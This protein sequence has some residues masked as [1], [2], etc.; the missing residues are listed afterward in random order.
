[1]LAGMGLFLFG[2][3]VGGAIV[4]LAIALVLFGV[5]AVAALR[6]SADRAN[7][8]LCFGATFALVLLVHVLVVRF[9]P[10][11]DVR[12]GSDHGIL[13]RNLFLQGLG[14]CSSPG[15]AGLLG[16]LAALLLPRDKPAAGGEA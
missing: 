12:P 4:G 5:G 3:M 14:Y 11:P 15:T 2:G 6:A 13:A 1:M 9:Y 16:G 7:A 8:W 10:Y